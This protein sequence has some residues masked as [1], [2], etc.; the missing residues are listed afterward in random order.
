MRFP[1]P[2]TAYGF[3][4]IPPSAIVHAIAMAIFG[5]PVNLRII[6]GNA[7]NGSRAEAALSSQ[8][9]NLPQ[10]AASLRGDHW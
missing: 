1:W 4:G 3:P 9:K 7:D 2:Q 6:R 10:Q 5:M 8:Q